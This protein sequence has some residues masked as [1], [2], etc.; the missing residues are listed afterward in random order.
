MTN[1]QMIMLKLI[2]MSDNDFAELMDNEITTL[3]GKDLCQYCKACHKG[4]CPTETGEWDQC[5]FN[6]VEWLQKQAS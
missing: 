6:L 2:Q 4:E 3:V 1:R 5:H